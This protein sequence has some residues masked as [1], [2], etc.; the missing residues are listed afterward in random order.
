MHL[1]V[2]KDQGPGDQTYHPMVD[3]TLAAD[4]NQT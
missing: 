1:G 2:Q 4:F 3:D